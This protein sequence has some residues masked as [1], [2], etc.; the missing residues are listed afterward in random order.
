MRQEVD[1]RVTERYLMLYSRVSAKRFEREKAASLYWCSRNAERLTEADADAISEL[2]GFELQGNFCAFIQIGCY[3]DIPP[4]RRYSAVF[5]L[6]NP[7]NGCIAPAR[8]HL[9]IFKRAL[10]LFGLEHGHHHVVVFEFREG[11]PELLNSLPLD[12]FDGGM[13]SATF[14]M[15]D[16]LVWRAICERGRDA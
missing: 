9:S 16:A 15:C 12:L 6:A 5:E 13:S 2:R 1:T 10:P 4:N 11:V 14:G 8:L 7:K 3:A